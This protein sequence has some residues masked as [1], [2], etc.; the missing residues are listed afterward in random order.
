MLS[1][2]DDIRYPYLKIYKIVYRISSRIDDAIVTIHVLSKEMNSRI[3][4]IF[5]HILP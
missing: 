2:R 4:R 1:L 5:R 3:A